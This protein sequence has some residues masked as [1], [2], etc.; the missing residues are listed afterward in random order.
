M[1]LGAR[2]LTV[3]KRGKSPVPAA[4]EPV[5]LLACAG[6]PIIFAEKARQSDI[7]VVCLGVPGMAD[8]DLKNICHEFHW[9]NRLSL[10]FVIR[11]F[12]R[13]GVS[14]WTMAGKF[15]KHWLYRPWRGCT[16]CRTGGCY[17]STTPGVGGPNNDDSLLLGLIAEFRA[18][19][20]DCLSALELCPEL[21]VKEGIL[22]AG[23]RLLSKNS[24]S[25][26][27][28]ARPGDGTTRHRPKRH[29]Q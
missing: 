8:P 22:T 29:D 16:F 2:L 3:G 9:L 14:R 26:R 19:G 15:H 25:R 4:R 1:V 24:T 21:L 6:R 11:T 13:G 10:G 23:V 5:G 7:P 17:A 20:L 12:R 27:A 18:A 28:G